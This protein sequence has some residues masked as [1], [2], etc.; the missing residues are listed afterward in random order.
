MIDAPALVP[1]LFVSIHQG[2]C[3]VESALSFAF[4]LDHNIKAGDKMK[5]ENE[6]LLYE[7]LNESY[8]GQWV[9]EFKGIEGRKYRFDAANPSK[10]IAMEIEGGLWIHGRHNRPIGM[11][12]DMTKYN[13]AVVDG[14]KVLRYSPEMLRKTP[15]HLIRDVRMLC[16]VIDAAQQTLCLDGLKQATL[17]EQVQVKLS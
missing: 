9:S 10:K 15:W 8:P 2:K 3:P 17:K 6:R 14:W 5:G 13:A 16:G 7:I 1:V 4:D 11:E 12:Q